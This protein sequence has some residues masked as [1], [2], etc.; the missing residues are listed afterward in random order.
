MLTTEEL[1]DCSR[2]SDWRGAF[3]IVF[4]WGLIAA[5]FAALFFYPHPLTY[6]LGFVLMA[7]HQLSLAI[8]MHDAA[9]RRLSNHPAFND[10]AAQL[11]LASPI[12]F[13][14]NS[15]RVF[16][17]KHHQDPLAPDDPDISLIGGYPVSKVSLARKLLR[18]ACGIS[19]CKF[20]RYFLSRSRTNQG[21]KAKSDGKKMGPNFGVVV[22]MTMAVNLCL[23]LALQLTGNGWH[24]VVFWLVPTMTALQVLLRVRGIAEHAG[25]RQNPDQ[26]LNAR[27]VVNPWQTF[28]FAPNG[29]NYHIEHHVY[30]SVPWYRLAEVHTV[31]EARGSLPEKNLY[32]GYGAVIR[33]LVT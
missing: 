21:R 1:R 14:L 24:Y 31:M 17:L 2:I 18:D 7:R 30:P 32:R 12:L 13:S 20:L 26:R 6:V 10:Y 29:V 28:F 27:T 22:V 3:W 33:E 11:F 19:Y 25:Y 8:L 9:H 16:H 23:L 4:T 5:T 15:Y